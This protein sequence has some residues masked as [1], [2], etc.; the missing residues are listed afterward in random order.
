MVSFSLVPRFMLIITVHETGFCVYYEE[1]VLIDA[2]LSPSSTTTILA[3]S[4]LFFF[5]STSTPAARDSP[6][7]LQG[8]LRNIILVP[9][10]SR[11]TVL[12]V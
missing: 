6:K 10:E 9:W 5:Y 12:Y 4:V 7:V 8:R 11:E 3:Y 1:V 2:W